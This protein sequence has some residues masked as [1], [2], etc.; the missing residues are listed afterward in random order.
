MVS[1]SRLIPR[2]AEPQRMGRDRESDLV[3][4]CVQ[5]L[6]LREHGYPTSYGELYSRSGD[7]DTSSSPRMI[8][9]TIATV[10]RLRSVATAPQAP[11]P[12]VDS[13]KCPRCSLVGICLPDETNAL[14]ERSVAQPRRLTPRDSEARPVY[15]TEQGSSC[16]AQGR[17]AGGVGGSRAAA[18]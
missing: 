13:P 4:L 8:A 2:R 6:L 14:S 16:G 10:E 15:V 17:P 1:S 9:R 7:G 5:G 12:L 3:Q 11:P 18:V